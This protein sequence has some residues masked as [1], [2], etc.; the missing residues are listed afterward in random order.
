MS[1]QF[2]ATVAGEDAFQVQ[3]AHADWRLTGFEITQVP[4][5]F[6]NDVR[7]RPEQRNV[8][9]QQLDL[10]LFTEHLRR[11]GMMTGNRVRAELGYDQRLVE[12]LLKRVQLMG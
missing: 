10:E 2:W 1:C 7:F 6:A 5:M 9:R 11:L 12:A 8:T 4:D 3:A